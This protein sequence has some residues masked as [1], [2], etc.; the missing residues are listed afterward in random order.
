MRPPCAGS[1]H[2]T[3]PLCDESRALPIPACIVEVAEDDD[4]A[5][6]VGD[7]LPVAAP[8]RAVG[9]PAVL[10]EPRLAHRVDGS[11]VDPQRL[12]ARIR[13]HARA[14]RLVEAPRPAHSNGV[15]TARRSGTRESGS[16]ASTRSA[17]SGPA[18]ARA[19]ATASRSRAARRR[20]GA[21]RSGGWG[22]AGG[23]EGAAGRPNGSAR[24]GR[25]RGGPPRA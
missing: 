24:A 15:R 21:S 2:G 8:Q 10:D 20:A 23:A 1:R 16:M 13:A 11:T 18:A 5:P 25:P 19:W 22:P 12:P 14:T 3:R 6:V 17:A 7:D 9:P 4:V